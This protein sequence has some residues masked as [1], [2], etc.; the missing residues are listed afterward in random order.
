MI[1]EQIGNLLLI[2]ITFGATY[3]IMTL[4]LSFIYG[5][6]KMFNYAHGAF[7][8]WAGYIAWMLLTYFDLNYTAVAIIIVPVMFLFGLAFEKA[9]MYP[10]RRF[11]SPNWEINV[12]IVTLGAGLLLGHLAFAIFDVRPRSLPLL[13]E[14]SFSLYGFLITWH[15]AVA[16]VAALAVTGLLSL[17]SWKVRQGMAMRAIAQDMTGARIV[18][19]PIDR[20]F[21]YSFAV[22]G[23]LAGI[24]AILLAPKLLIHP[25]VGWM[26]F[27]RAFV[28]MVFGG[29]GSLKGTVVAAF[30][31]AT[32]EAFVTFYLG[33]VWAIPT[34]ISVLVF[35][36]IIRPKGLFGQW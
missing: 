31:M 22:A 1:A 27:V 8:I 15:D 36:L 24:S 14:G 2:G 7:Y 35:V 25:Q 19:I 10:L 13:V 5:V 18:G 29:L 4:G 17:Y 12:I 30:I 23:A 3:T 6:T 9:L 11:P 16:V 28:I 21:G 33:G 26:I 34:F 32:I 20:M